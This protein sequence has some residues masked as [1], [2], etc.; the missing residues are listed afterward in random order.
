MD[1]GYEQTEMETKDDNALD[2]FQIC[3]FICL[4]A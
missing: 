1:T 3:N 4:P 2:A